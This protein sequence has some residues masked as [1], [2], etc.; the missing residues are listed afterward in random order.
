MLL[1]KEK[2]RC[3]KNQAIVVSRDAGQSR[4]HRATNPGREYELRHYKLDGDL[5]KN[6]T[7]CDFLLVNDSS[8]KAYFIE[9]KG[10]NIDDAVD[11]LE[12]GTKRFASELNG[13]MF[14]YR[15]V[16]SRALTHKVR[17][18]KYLKF[19]ER[20]GSRLQTKERKLEEILD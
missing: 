7:C 19:K 8:R 18:P 16:C 13:Y 11:Q 4:E 15:I 12:A 20:C 10:E 6:E 9:L 14:L 1:T 17:N 2:S 3:D 5:V